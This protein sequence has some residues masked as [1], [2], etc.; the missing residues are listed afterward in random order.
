MKIQMNWLTQQ[1]R[2]MMTSSVFNVC[3]DTLLDFQNLAHV[4]YAILS[5]G[6]RNALFAPRMELNV[7]VVEALMNWKMEYA[8]LVK[9]KVNVRCI[10][11]KINHYARF[12]LKGIWEKWM[13][14]LVSKN[15]LR[16]IL[17]IES[18]KSVILINER[19]IEWDKLKKQVIRF[20]LFQM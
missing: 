13:T 15:V 4:F 17:F 12:V 14:S 11:L 16:D 10:T 7:W 6:Y 1:G 2:M 19:K 3:Q 9:M 8:C 20:Q 18:R 5:Q